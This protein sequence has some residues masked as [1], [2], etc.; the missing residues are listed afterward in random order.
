LHID[1]KGR[2]ALVI[3]GTSYIGSCVVNT[4]AELGA[5]VIFTGSRQSGCKVSAGDSRKKP[6]HYIRYRI[7]QE[8]DL[9]ELT[10]A[11]Q[12]IFAQRLHILVYVRG[13]VIYKTLKET[14]LAELTK[15]FA[16][17]L[18]GFFEVYKAMDKFLAS[19]DYGRIVAFTCA[20][21]EYLSA[22]KMMPAYYAAKTALS[23][24]LRSLAYELSDRRITVNAIA[25][26]IM[27]GSRLPRGRARLKLPSGRR[28][29]CEDIA[30]ALKLI[31][32]PKSDYLTGS[33]LVVSGGFSL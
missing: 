15:L 20:G 13:P 14:S 32:S 30:T 23:S 17:N 12:R 16:E 18:F 2:N 9:R 33:F 4:I 5:K 8:E 24:V 26:G 31:L 28:G 29:T 21:S 7:G 27:E 19:N 6:A 3:G 10:S 11:V 25:P 1:L 22:K